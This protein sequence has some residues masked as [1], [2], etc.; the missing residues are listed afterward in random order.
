MTTTPPTGEEGSPYSELWFLQ[1]P[2]A[3]V[4]GSSGCWYALELRNGL[5]PLL[6]APFSTPG[7]QTR[8]LLLLLCLCP[9][10]HFHFRVELRCIQAGGQKGGK[11]ANSPRFDGALNSGFLTQSAYY[12][13][14]RALILAAPCILSRFSNYIP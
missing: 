10:A 1:P 3:T 2:P 8:G 13:L 5:C 14:F 4:T 9:G 11:M 6:D 12:L 7:A